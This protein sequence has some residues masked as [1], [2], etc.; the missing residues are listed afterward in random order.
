MRRSRYAREFPIVISALGVV[1]AFG[2]ALYAGLTIQRIGDHTQVIVPVYA[3]L[4]ALIL[5]IAVNAT[6]GIDYKGVRQLVCAFALTQ[7][8][9]EI[10]K[11]VIDAPRPDG[12]DNRSFPSGH[13]AS[14]FCG[15]AFIHRRYGFKRAIIP[16]L[17]AVFTGYSRVYANRHYTH[18]VIASAVICG[19]IVW[20]L[21]SEYKKEQISVCEGE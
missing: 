13:A 19:F 20:L 5:G 8:T 3:L 16:Y 4:Y 17:L 18:D 7:A 6:T 14:A 1:L 10:L 2:G 15:A 9:V 12:G 21:V 11:F